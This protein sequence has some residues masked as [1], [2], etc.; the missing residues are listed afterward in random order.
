MPIHRS[1]LGVR[2]RAFKESVDD[3]RET[4]WS[5]W[6]LTGPRTCLFVITFIAEHNST[7]E[8]R[9]VR[10]CTEGRLQQTD[11]GAA[12]HGVLLKILQLGASYDQCDL[13]QLAWVARCV[14]VEYSP[15][16]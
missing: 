16:S 9:R 3:M 8:Q 1:G 2:H 7:P 15:S 11:P 14:L 13:P 6:P 4:A 10:F 5:D 12:E